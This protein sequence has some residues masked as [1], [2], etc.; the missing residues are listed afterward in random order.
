[1]AQTKDATLA[2]WAHGHFSSGHMGNIVLDLIVWWLRKKS[3]NGGL[4]ENYHDRRIQV[5][6][7]IKSTL[8]IQTPPEDFVGLTV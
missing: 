3:S 8:S 1:M 4:M 6:N 7:R 5:V 2:I